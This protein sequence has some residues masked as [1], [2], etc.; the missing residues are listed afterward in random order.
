MP[1]DTSLPRYHSHILCHMSWYLTQKLGLSLH[2]GK[3]WLLFQMQ[4]CNHLVLYSEL[5]TD[6]LSQLKPEFVLQ[7]LALTKFSY[8]FINICRNDLITCCDLLGMYCSTIFG[9]MQ[10]VHVHSLGQEY[11]SFFL[12]IDILLF[13][14]TCNYRHFRGNSQQSWIYNPEDQVVLLQISYH[15]FCS[16]MHC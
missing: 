9:R 16:F 3:L 5:W 10:S 12:N 6:N 2:G 1:I 15:H 13:R 4:G 7:L 14:G 11:R 8:S